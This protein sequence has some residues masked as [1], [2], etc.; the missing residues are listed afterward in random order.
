MPP[1]L[2]IETD[3]KKKGYLI[4]A[5]IDE[6]GI[7]PLAG[8]V[9]SAAVILKKNTKLPYLDSSKKISKKKREIL[10]EQITQKALDYTISIMSHKTI[11]DLN[12]FKAVRHA[13]QLC[14]KHL[15]IKPDIVLI[16]GRD[17]QILKIPY[18]TIIKG[19]EKIKSIAAASILAK[20][21]RDR[22]MEYYS[23]KFTKYSFEKHKGYPTRK[24]RS[25][26]REYGPCEIHR[27]SYN[28][29]G[30]RSF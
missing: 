12:V 18:K 7:G 25:I 21:T 29:L 26:L 4:I 17:K 11:D 8:P 22:I 5:G 14:I 1:F 30:L 16:D 6:A 9:V 28:L 13:N 23:E 15:R 20:V 24:H 19:D 3:L 2:P 27:G 10:Y